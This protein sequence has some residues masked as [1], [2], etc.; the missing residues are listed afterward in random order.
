MANRLYRFSTLS[1]WFTRYAPP[2]PAV[3]M[4]LGIES[5]FLLKLMMF[6]N[7]SVGNTRSLLLQ[8]YKLNV[9]ARLVGIH[10]RMALHS[11]NLSVVLSGLSV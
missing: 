6:F 5:F 11:V 3:K 1:F 2:C 4:P 7:K 10:G 9:V 8:Q